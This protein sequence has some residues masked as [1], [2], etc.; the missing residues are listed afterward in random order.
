MSQFHQLIRSSSQR[1]T[2]VANALRTTLGALILASTLAPQSASAQTQL[3]TITVSHSSGSGF[4]T[5]RWDTTTADWEW[6]FTDNS[7][8]YGTYVGPPPA[9]ELCPALEEQWE[10]SDCP[11][12]TAFHDN[13]CGPDGLLSWAVPDAP[14]PNASFGDACNS[15]DSCYTR[16]G[17]T[18]AACD[19]ALGQAA[20]AACT[21]AAASFRSEGID[22]GLS[23]SR[24]NAYVSERIYSCKGFATIY[25]GAVMAAGAPHFR[26]A[27]TTSHCREMRELSNQYGCGL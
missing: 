15:H 27:Q 13:G 10:N 16:L 19:A 8:G 22:L 14:V 23:G 17:S 3:G 9:S 18:Q 1:R 11:S 6:I 20:N 12:R 2:G 24:L 25:L 26:L 21:N 7:G 5:G 4:W